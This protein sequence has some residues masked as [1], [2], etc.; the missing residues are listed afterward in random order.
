MFLMERHE[1]ILL[2]DL[3]EFVQQCIESGGQ[4]VVI[5]RNP[6]G[7]TCTVSVQRE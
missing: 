2:P 7:L 1:K 5:T 3:G 4:I 6:D